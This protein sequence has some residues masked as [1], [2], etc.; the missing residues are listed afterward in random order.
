MTIF[1]YEEN[2]KHGKIPD[3]QDDQIRQMGGL[4]VN[5]VYIDLAPFGWFILDSV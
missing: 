5:G 1:R 4:D 3:S 2:I